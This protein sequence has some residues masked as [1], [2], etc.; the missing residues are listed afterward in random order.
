VGRAR[1]TPRLSKTFIRVHTRA[2]AGRGIFATLQAL[3]TIPLGAASFNRAKLTTHKETNNMTSHEYAQKL[4]ETV[5]FLLDH[6]EVELGVGL[7]IPV[8]MFGEKDR[9]LTAAKAF[10]SGA[11][12]VDDNYMRFTPAGTVL[13]LTIERSSVCRKVQE[14]KWECEPLL[15][16]T[17][18]AQLE[19]A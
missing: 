9:F 11:K 13:V 2:A 1:S 8:Y 18:E 14:E 5:A 3:W 4:Q 6:S 17:E 16:Q 12:N 15:S 10:G 7:S 19:V